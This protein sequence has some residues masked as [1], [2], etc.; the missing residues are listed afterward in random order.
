MTMLDRFR[1]EFAPRKRPPTL[2]VGEENVKPNPQQLS[3]F[4]REP[5]PF[6]LLDLRGLT[7]SEFCDAQGRCFECD[8]QKDQENHQ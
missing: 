5:L 6:G 8:A 7:V 1:T 2:A 4:R 3:L